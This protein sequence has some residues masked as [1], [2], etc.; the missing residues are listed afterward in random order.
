MRCA[1]GTPKSKRTML[2]R[3]NSVCVCT[4]CRSFPLFR[5]NLA[6]EYCASWRIERNSL[7]QFQL[8]LLPS[9]DCTD[10]PPL[11]TNHF[12]FPRLLSTMSVRI[13]ISCDHGSHHSAH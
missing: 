10:E 5:L 7:E 11:S 3:T 1:N 13:L 2:S 8:A 12:P 6:T 4:I 9:S